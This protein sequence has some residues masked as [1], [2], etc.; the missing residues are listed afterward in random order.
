MNKT[1]EISV[2]NQLEVV[3][4]VID[5]VVGAYELVGDD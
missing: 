4:W 3:D 1:F 5:E 2:V